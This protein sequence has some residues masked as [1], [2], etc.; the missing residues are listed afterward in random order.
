MSDETIDSFLDV[1]TLKKNLEIVNLD[2][3]LAPRR[4]SKI[5]EEEDISWREEAENCF[6]GEYIDED[7]RVGSPP[8]KVIRIDYFEPVAEVEE[9]IQKYV[10]DRYSRLL[11]EEDERNYHLF[12][13]GDRIFSNALEAVRQERISNRSELT[14]PALVIDLPL[15]Y[16]EHANINQT[17]G[18]SGI[19]NAVPRPDQLVSDDQFSIEYP[20]NSIEYPHKEKDKVSVLTDDLTIY[21]NNMKDLINHYDKLDQLP[22]EFYQIMNEQIDGFTG[23]LN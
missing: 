9:Q 4:L 11:D 17:L 8:R 12:L 23:L 22:H 14:F 20:H 2:E 13:D 3:I 6:L 19:E 16:D 10:E 7:P 1:E 18:P 21:A 5:I 15:N